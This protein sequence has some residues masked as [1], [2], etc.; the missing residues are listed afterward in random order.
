[1]PSPALPTDTASGTAEGAT[2]ASACPWETALRAR[3]PGLGFAA[4]NAAHLARSVGGNGGTIDDDLAPKTD[5][6]LPSTSEVL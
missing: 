4:K 1:M 2:R 6:I 5:P 3:T